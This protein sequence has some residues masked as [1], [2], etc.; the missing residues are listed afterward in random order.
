MNDVAIRVEGLGKHYRIGRRERYRTLRDTI[1]EIVTAPVRRA[2]SLFR[3]RTTQA[4]SDDLIW[5]LRDVSFEVPAGSVVG[6]IGRNGAGKSTLLKILSRITEQTEGRIELR[7]RVGSLLE[8]GTG[9]HPELSG[10]ENIFLNG[11]I[12][13]MRRSEIVRKFDEIVSFAE[14][15]R[16]ID[17]PVKHYSTGMYMRLAFSVAAHLEPEILLVDEV[18]AVGDALFQK[19]CLG[20]IGDV[21]KGGR[22]V[23]F[24]SHNMAAIR[25]LCSVGILLRDGALAQTSSLDDAIRHYAG[26]ADDASE[27]RRPETRPGSGANLVF[28]RLRCEVIGDQPNLT[29]SIEGEL[30]SIRPHPPALLAFDVLDAYSVPLFQSLPEA[31]PFIGYSDQPLHFDVS[32]DLPPLVPGTYRVGAWA[33]THYAHTIDLV[34]SALA[35][36]ILS[37]PTPGRTYPHTYDHGAIVPRSSVRLRTGTHSFVPDLTAC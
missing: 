25:Q 5:A 11:A 22:T 18:L 23:V 33:G 31:E 2:G 27:W 34:E 28:E 26:V 12:L 19:K 21:A 17:T 7:G 35:F 36:T 9:F 13:G 4:E 20:K 29:L 16:F 37:S 32:I 6:V 10:R 1:A 3:K 24:V 14:V 15:E 8:V 30:R